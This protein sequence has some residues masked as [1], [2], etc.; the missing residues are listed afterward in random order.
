MSPEGTAVAEAPA[1]KATMK[2]KKNKARGRRAG[3]RHVQTCVNLPPALKKMVAAKAR[4]MGV[5]PSAFMR[6]AIAKAAGFKIAS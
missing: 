3:S 5:K 2:N 6:D 1:K 4:K